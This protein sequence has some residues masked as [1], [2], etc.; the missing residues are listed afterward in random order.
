ME[1][2][3]NSKTPSGNCSQMRLGR[4]CEPLLKSLLLNRGK[5]GASEAFP[6]TSTVVLGRV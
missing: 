3:Q 6:G 1:Q 5:G 2:K 4:H